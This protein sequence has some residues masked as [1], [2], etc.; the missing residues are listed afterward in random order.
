[1]MI[2]NIIKAATCRVIC[3]KE[4]G[5]GHLITDSYVLTARHCIIPAIVSENTI[6]LTFFGTE[7]E[8]NL[9]AS[10]VEHSE[11]LDAC[12]LLLPRPL[13][14]QPI[15]LNTTMPREGVDWR[16][17]GYPAGKTVIGH[18]IFGTISHLL[19]N[20]R[21]KMDIDLAVDSSVAPGDYGGLSGAALV[22]DNACRGMIRMRLN[23][24]LGAISI[25]QLAGFLEKYGIQVPKPNPEESTPTNQRNRWANRSVFQETFERTIR[26]NAGNYIFLEGAHGLGKTTFCCD[27]R[28]EDQALFTLG[29]YSFTLQSRGPGV[30]YRTQPDVFFDW[31]STT[32]STLITGKLPRMEERSYTTLVKD[33]SVLLEHFS[34][35]CSSTNRQGILF[36]DGLDEAQT[37]DSNSMAKLLGLFPFPLP[38]NITIILTAPNYQTLANLLSGRVKSQN[39]ITLPFLSDEAS[40]NYCWQELQEVKANTTLV[41]HIV[42]KAKGHP[43][44]LRYLIEYVNSSSTED[45]LDDFP[46]LSGLIEEYYELLWQRLLEDTNA[47][48]LLAIF[49]RLR[50]GIEISNLPKILTSEEQ[51][52]FTTT[53]SRIR[54]LLVCQDKTTIYHP[55]FAE[56]VALKTASLETIIQRRL[57]DFCFRESD[58]DYCVLNLVFHL[59]HSDDADRSR[60]IYVCNQDWVDNCVTCGVE[61][62]TLL[63]DI[64]ETV[65]AATRLGPA[66]EVIRLLLLSQRISFR[67]NVL[68]AQSARLVTD[69]LISLKR[70]KEALQHVI[71]FNT[72]IVDPNEALQIALSF[73]QHEYSDEALELLKTLQLRIVES[74]NVTN[75]I[76]LDNFIYLCRLHL[77]AIHFM[78]LADG[79]GR[80]DQVLNILEYAKQVIQH[81][82]NEDSLEISNYYLSQLHSVG[83]SY[84]LC[85]RDTY[86]SLARLKEIDSDIPVINLIFLLIWTLFECEKSLSIYNLPKKIESLPQVFSDIE[87]LITGGANFDKR[88]IPEIVDTLIQLGASSD[89]IQFVD[90]KG[91]K[92]A[93]ITKSIQI[94]AENGVD[95]DFTSIQRSAVEWRT[96]AFIDSQF[97][98]PLIAA[99]DETGWQSALDQQ[100][101]ALFWCEGKARRSMADG[102]E[103]LRQQTL[104]FLKNRVLKSLTFSLA[105][106][107]KWLDSYAIPENIFPW[108]YEQIT[109]VLRDCY[110]NELSSFLEDLL[111][112]A[113]DQLGLYTEGFREVIFAVLKRLSINEIETNIFDEIL[114]LLNCWK[115]HVINGVENR[116]E[117]VPELLKMIPLFAKVGANEEADNLYKYMLSVSMG[118]SWYKED[119]LGV[120]VSTL[121]NMPLSDDVHSSIPLIAGYLERASG[122]MTF[123]RFIRYEKMALIGELFRRNSIVC[124]CRYFKRQT[125]GTTTELLL[126]MQQGTIDKPSSS[127]GLRY[128][129]A[130][131]DNQ[132]AILHIVRNTENADWRLCWSLLEIY[133]CG[134]ERHFDDFAS[135]YALLINREGTDSNLSLDLVSRLEFVVG[136]EIAPKMRTRFVDSFRKKLNKEHHQAFSKIM[137]QYTADMEHDVKAQFEDSAKSASTIEGD[138]SYIDDKLFFPGTFGKQSAIRDAENALLAAEKQLKLK[139]M[140]AAKTQAVKVLQTL[141]DGGWS[142]WGMNL[143]KTHRSAEDLL[144]QHAENPVEL[145]RA[146]SSLI[147]AERYVSKWSIADHLIEKVSDL[148]EI[149]EK[150]QL[151]QYVIDHIHLMVGDATNEIVMFDFLSEKS[152]CDISE[153]LFKFITWHLDHPKLIQRDKSA[154]MIAWLVDRESSPY[155]GIATKEAFSMATG[156]SP[157]IFCGILD[158]M[159]THRPLQ[160]WDQIYVF[161]DIDDILRNCVHVSR[162][163]VLHRIADKAGKAGSITGRDAASRIV[164]VF[165]SGKIELADSDD[166]AVGALPSW[167]LC[168]KSEWKLLERLELATKEIFSCLEVKMSEICSPLNIQENWKLENAV[169]KAFRETE[170]HHLNRW[171]AKVRF[172]LNTSL[173]SYASQRDFIKIESVLRVFNP[174]IPE[175]SLI[176]DFASPANAVLKA[177]NSGRDYL[178]AIGDDE[179]LFLAYNEITEYGT[180]GKMAHLE[181]LAVIIPTLSSKG[182]FFLPSLNNSFKSNE[183][184]NLNSGITYHETCW[185]LEPDFV[186]FGSFTPGFPLPIFKDLIKAQETDFHRV[187]WRNGRSDNFRFFAR[188]VQEG[189][190][191]TA[192]RKAV[193]LPEGKK[194][195]WIIKMDGKIVT[196]VDSKNNQLI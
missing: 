153:E 4:Y 154:G 99:F 93:P 64:E 14:C 60:A 66:V 110:P 104:D 132:H 77:W 157:D 82:L 17:F 180:A 90:A 33:T 56:F 179:Y 51:T 169:S 161:L 83:S 97:D 149:N 27:F 116:H 191:L 194:L 175:Q 24:S 37:A 124:G 71:R 48:N 69:T 86:A 131:L 159:S 148:L 125:C 78:R 170:N 187:N 188:P 19:D 145:L 176:P 15:P 89:I 189:C 100:I 22:S 70:P 121:R 147:A 181:V 59:L 106:R 182:N 30:I 8:T 151:L 178:S 193:E 174:I 47:I 58:L 23:G 25:Q 54:H 123:Q 195:A 112:R 94:R 81:N 134:D 55:S 91:D 129:G 172:A 80:M 98:C 31:L 141:Q 135:E 111:D 144:R 34:K 57:A 46:I 105:E 136:A 67:Y 52:S 118:P 140:N 63:F 36:L 28:T 88:L 92:S 152:E 53:V 126:E 49:A 162:L 158:S 122:E 95:V 146:Y 74:Y 41:A 103:S 38:N 39:V 50:W 1:M 107:V 16:S 185:H 184:P 143:G 12:I 20:A 133:Q 167:A 79:H 42:E 26:N 173:F 5:T 186:F 75:G 10:I 61:P 11:E 183:I 150:C 101:C 171:E 96:K 114:G 156:F 29:T 168:V 18:R 65:A 76:T 45:T 113:K 102:D 192:K 62:D 196:V 7:G 155:L 160:L 166:Y 163:A 43:L 35:Y 21:L 117:L 32:I 44:Y 142:I 115:E 109:L 177:I 120:M 40:S 165:R 139:N 13:N 2:D 9:Q 127:V 190:L 6:E 72:L 87:D 108:I 84:F 164:G 128:P 137:S 85:F 73:I 119:Q 68:F 138:D 3:G 130:A